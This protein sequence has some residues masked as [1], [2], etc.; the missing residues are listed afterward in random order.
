MSWKEF[1]KMD[2][3]ERLTIGAQQSL[4]VPM[5]LKR[6]MFFFTSNYLSKVDQGI[7]NRCQK[8]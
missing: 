6:C 8:L 5:W 3:V 4:R 1:Q 7:L 2:K